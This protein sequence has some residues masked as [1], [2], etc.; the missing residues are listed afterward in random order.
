MANSYSVAAKLADDSP[1]VWIA[2][3]EDQATANLCTKIRR[4]NID[5][6]PPTRYEVRS[7]RVGD[8]ERV[9]YDIE[10]RA[11]VDNDD[12]EF[13]SEAVQRGIDG[14]S[15]G[16]LLSDGPLSQLH[17]VVTSRVLEA[18]KSRNE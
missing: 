3:R 8:G 17:Q 16:Q 13:I 5:K 18:I 6:L 9:L 15:A 14:W 10:V 2:L 11:K 4:G 1:G 7:C 12:L